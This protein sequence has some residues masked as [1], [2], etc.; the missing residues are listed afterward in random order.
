M[1]RTKEYYIRKKRLGSGYTADSV[2]VGSPM[3]SWAVTDING[4][5][6][7]GPYP[8]H[9]AA[10]RVVNIATGP[11]QGVK[12]LGSDQSILKTVRGWMKFGSK[13]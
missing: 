10:M 11:L 6:V 5:E 8:S 13:K 3:P 1:K 12:H 9:K 7:A 2:K 4:Q